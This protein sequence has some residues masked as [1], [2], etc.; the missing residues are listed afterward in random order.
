MPF[1]LATLGNLRLTPLFE[2]PL[3]C[4]TSASVATYAQPGSTNSAQPPAV[5]SVR[6]PPAA[7]TGTSRLSWPIHINP[8]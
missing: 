5:S 1:L 8:T 6:P 3:F 2:C 7:L 4:I